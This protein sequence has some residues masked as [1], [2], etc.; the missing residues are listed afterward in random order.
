MCNCEDKAK[1]YFWD[2]PHHITD[3]NGDE[4]DAGWYAIPDWDDD[5]R[6]LVWAC[7]ER[8][9]VCADFVRR[10]AATML[11]Q[12]NCDNCCRASLV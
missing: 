10:L 8:R 9:A 7:E 1:V 3:C 4:L 6:I 5:A 11:C 2:N 12:G